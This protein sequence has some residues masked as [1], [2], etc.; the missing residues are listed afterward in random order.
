MIFKRGIHLSRLL[1]KRLV[2]EITYFFVR[3][4]A[5][6]LNAAV[7]TDYYDRFD[8]G[9]LKSHCRGKT[10]FILGS[11]ASLAQ[12]PNELVLKMRENTTM[13]LNYSLLQSFLPADFHV[14]RE[15]GAAN[16][17][18]ID[19]QQS[20]LKK[21]GAVIKSN[22]QYQETVFLVQGGF[23]AWAANLFIGW[24]CLPCGAK[25]FRF[26][27]SLSPIF[28]ALSD[29]FGSIVH[30]AS[31]ITDCINLGYLMEFNKI[32]LCGVDLYDRRYFWHVG[33]T[34]HMQLNGITD[35]ELGEYGEGGDL[36]A[37]HR[38]ARRLVGQIARW[39]RDL[40]V[41]GVELYV[42]N[43][44]S[45]L[46]EVLPIYDVSGS[47]INRQNSKLNVHNN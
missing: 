11:G 33:N 15:L 35:S 40:K 42:Q 31:S 45:L 16:D 32:V 18:E 19:I 25:I 2:T 5:M 26:R 37:R 28:G 10:L 8:Q 4:R 47:E 7:P 6:K 41:N 34:P 43:P 1:L 27:N 29:A 20:D 21:L 30:G 46:T 9:R 24:R 44:R 14:V 13:S 3:A 22:P 38:A 17:E 36:T 39:Q 12:L 23:Y